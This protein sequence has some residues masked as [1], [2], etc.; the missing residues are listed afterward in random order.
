MIDNNDVMRFVEKLRIEKKISI[1]D[2]TE[3]IISRRSYSRF[4]SPSAELQVDTL[5]KLLERMKLPVFEFGA[6]VG[7]SILIE[8][9][10]EMYF[11]EYIFNELYE[12][13]YN[14]IYPLIKDKELK[15]PLA[16]KSIP[17][18]IKLMEYKLNKITKAE[19]LSAMKNVIEL[20]TMINSKIICFDDIQA[21]SL[22]TLVCNDE[23]KE[24]I[25]DH[26]LKI[27]FTSKIKVFTNSVEYTNSVIH[28]IA[29]TTLTTK[30]YTTD[31][32]RKNIQKLL[33]VIFE[34][35]IKAKT[36]FHDFIIFNNLYK[37]VKKHKID[38]KLVIFHYLASIAST[39]GSAYLESNKIKIDQS[40]IEIYLSFLEDDT[41]LK[42]PTYEGLMDYEIL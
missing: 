23:A 29:L 18:A 11:Y 24:L 2:L 5:F 37:Y 26:M 38:N 36:A 15:S 39:F 42:K 13:A 1:H 35:Q 9:I 31:K 8:N 33:T 25:S 7:N 10:Y 40:D 28:R 16:I 21:L 27:L 12:T 22:Y 19:A 3:G 34:Y 14:E 6:Y 30:E 32:D 17:I 20:N 4:L 41:F